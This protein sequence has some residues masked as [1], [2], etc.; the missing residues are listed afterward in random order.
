M[1]KDKSTL[2]SWGKFL[3]G[4]PLGIIAF[5]YILNFVLSNASQVLPKI[6]QINP[7]FLLLSF[8]CFIVCY[9]LRILS[10][11]I[12]LKEKGHRLPFR[13]TLYRWE[14]S[15]VKRYVPGN[16][17]SFLSR[18]SLFEDAGVPKKTSAYLILI[19][20]ELII[21]STLILSTLSFP[22]ILD[23]LKLSDYANPVL[24]ITL[25]LI[26]LL[27]FTFI[28]GF[29]FLK[30]RLAK[31]LPDFQI[32]TNI[33]LLVIYIMAFFFFGLGTYLSVASIFVLNLNQAV[34]LVG[35]FSFSLLVGYLSLI[36][37]SGIGV[38]EG[39]ITFGLSSLLTTGVAGFV[40]VFSRLVLV[41]TELIFLFFIFLWEKSYRK[42]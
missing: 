30:G 39:V 25:I 34:T 31:S 13:E 17:W 20:I 9:V 32:F 41:A 36:T 6:N 27:F 16:V 19:E 5:I 8:S 26:S 24:L 38:R 14:F 18:A 42:T 3:I 7:L 40:A 15:E 11:Q 10:W 35:F 12:M 28:K 2:I 21:L 23:F 29:S 1:L 22:L 37:P 33:K 4:W